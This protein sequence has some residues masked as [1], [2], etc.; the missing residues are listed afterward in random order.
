M[1]CS[2]PRA[3]AAEEAAFSTARAR[4]S[5]P[6]LKS[7]LHKAP[8]AMFQHRTDP[9]PPP[10]TMRLPRPSSRAEITAAAVGALSASP[11]APPPEAASACAATASSSS[12]TGASAAASPSA[13]K[14]NTR[15]PSRRSQTHT[16]PSSSAEHARWNAFEKF[17]ETTA[18]AC[19]STLPRTFVSSAHT[20]GCTDAVTSDRRFGSK[21]RL[22]TAFS[23]WYSWSSVNVC[24][25]FR[26]RT[27]HTL[28]VFP[29]SSV[30]SWSSSSTHSTDVTGCSCPASC[31]TGPSESGFHS[32]TTRSSPAVYNVLRSSD[33]AIAFT[34]LTCAFFVNRRRTC[35]PPSRPSTSTSAAHPSLPPVAIAFS[36]AT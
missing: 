17:T 11:A 21:H 27:S 36:L 16:T 30:T 19:A 20:F 28:K 14:R 5:S 34:P 32:F 4:G 24:R 33:H 12:P 1:F 22:P 15:P 31:A 8:L 29:K 35:P 18:A 2:D 7:S 25:H 9:S 26:V 3:A 6:S 13:L 23:G 10:T